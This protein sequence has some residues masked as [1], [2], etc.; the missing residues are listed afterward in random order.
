MQYFCYPYKK[1][2]QALEASEAG[3]FS[4][5]APCSRKRPCR[6]G[7]GY[8]KQTCFRHY[9]KRRVSVG[10]CL[11]D[12]VRRKKDMMKGVVEEKRYNNRIKKEMNK[13]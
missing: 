2:G 5:L 8:P 7:A 4:D 10:V 12:E 13:K 1:A 6:S 11:E 9:D 3:A